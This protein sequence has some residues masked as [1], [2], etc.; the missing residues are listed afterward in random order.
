MKYRRGLAAL[1][2]ALAALSGCS[3]SSRDLEVTVNG[4]LGAPVTISVSGSRAPDELAAQTLIEGQGAPVVKDGPVLLRVTSFDSRTGEIV[5]SYETG[6]LRVTTANREGL[7]DLSEQI[8][9]AQE[10]SRLLVTRPELIEGNEAAEII[11][12]DLLSTV[13]N[14]QAVPLPTSPP[15][16]LPAVEVA[17]N[18]GPAIMSGGGAIPELAVVPLIEGDG[19]QVIEEDVLA[20]Q[21][22]IADEKGTILDTTWD[23]TGPVSVENSELMDGLH[24]GLTDQHVGSRVLVLVPSAMASGDGD[25]VAVVD[26]LGVL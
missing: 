21:Y 3:G 11:V 12:V 2:I 15:A 19:A 26:I 10:G 9:G 13:A 22:V 14:G 24:I 6:D 20:I 25:R 7:G 23:G 16:G 8:V 1:S 17:E 4:E 5:D 18:G